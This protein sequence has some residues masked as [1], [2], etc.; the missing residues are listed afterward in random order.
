[1]C[2][3]DIALDNNSYLLW[4][5]LLH[6]PAEAEFLDAV[7]TKF[8]GVFLLA[9]HSLVCN[10]NIEYGNLKSE[11]FQDYDKKEPQRNCTFMNS[12]SGLIKGQIKSIDL[13]LDQ[14]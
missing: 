5:C 3:K 9:I 1:M 14:P 8:I 10:V 7:E 13:L 11:K 4:C 12:A 6:P 2:N